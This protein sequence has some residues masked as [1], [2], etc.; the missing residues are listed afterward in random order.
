VP[1]DLT[2]FLTALSLWEEKY[3]ISHQA[4][5]ELVEMLCLIENIQEISGIPRRK[6]T[7]PS[8][9]KRSLSRLT[10]RKKTLDLDKAILPSLSTLREDLLVFG[11]RSFIQA[12]LSSENNIRHIYR[13]MTY[14]VDGKIEDPWPSR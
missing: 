13:G 12:L 14:R 8:R 3:S 11:V 7:L 5:S 6:D 2:P 1:L 4:Q 9:L 10:L